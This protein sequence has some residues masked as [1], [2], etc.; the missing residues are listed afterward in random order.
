MVAAA[1]VLSIIALIVVVYC[2]SQVYYFSQQHESQTDAA[3][4]SEFVEITVQESDEY[5]AIAYSLV[6]AYVHT[7]H[8]R[9][10]LIVIPWECRHK[11]EAR[12]VLANHLCA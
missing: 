11:S 9:T 2:L 10:L 3:Y 1:Y 4:E 6:S 7:R 12:V 5:T 8:S